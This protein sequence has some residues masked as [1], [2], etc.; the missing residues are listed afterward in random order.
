MKK[1]LLCLV[2]SMAMVFTTADSLV[3][4]AERPTELQTAVGE[5]QEETS[6][7]Q[8][9]VTKQPES[10]QE[11]VS[12]E[13]STESDQVEDTA[14]DTETEKETTDSDEETTDSEEAAD[15]DEEATDSGEATDSDEENMDSG[16]TTDSVEETTEPETEETADSKAQSSEDRSD[17]EKNDTDS[18]LQVEYHSI[19]EII[20]FLDQEKA[21]KADAVIYTERP[22]LTAPYQAGALSDTTLRSAAAM[23]RQIRFIAGLSYELQLNDE[24]NHISQAAALLNSANQELCQ[25]PSRPEGMS[26]ELFE[27]GRKGVSNSNLAY[28]G[29]QSQTLNGTIIETWMAD[30]D[31]YSQRGRLLQP[32]L[33]QIGFGVVQDGNGMYSAMYT[34]DRSDKGATVFGVAWPAQ[35]MPVDYFDREL[36]WSVSTGE[37]LEASD[38]RVTLTREA[39]GKEWTFSAEKSDGSFAVD[40]DDCG[41]SGCISFRP[42][43]SDISE[44]ADGDAFQVEITKDE[45]PY[46]KYRVRFFAY[47]KEEE[48]TTAPEDGITDEDTPERYTVNFESNGGTVVPAQSI[49]ENDK[50]IL[51]EQP[52]KEGSFFD[53]W[54][55]EEELENKWDFET[56]VV[57]ADIT[58]YAKWIGEEE[59]VVEPTEEATEADTAYSVTYDM[60]GI[61]E[62]IA[63][64]TINEGEILTQPDIPVAEDYIFEAW[65]QEQECINLWDFETD[66][67]TQDTVLYAKW[68]QENETAESADDLPNTAAEEVRID[69]SAE[70][71]DTRTNKI[72]PRVYNGKAYEPSVK[73]TAFNGKRR[74]T[75]KKNKDYKLQY[76]NNVHAGEDKATVTISGMGKYTGSVTKTFTITPKSVKKLKI[77]TG[78]KL[79]GDKGVAIVIYDGTVRLNNGWFLAEYI[80]AQDPKKAKI[81]IKPKETTTDYTGSVTSKL[82][83]YDV[84]KE[85]YINTARQEITGDTLYTGKA[86]KR[87]VKLTIED[88]ELRY[89][90]DYKVQYKNNVNA[91]TAVM[92]ITGKGQYKGKI[93]NTFNIGKV[94]LNKKE[95]AENIPQHVTIADISAKTFSGREQKPAVTI[96]TMG[97]K[98]LTLNKDYTVTYSNNVHAGTATITIAGI[99]SNCN[100]KTSIKFK[101]EPQQIKKAAVKLIRG[102]DGAPNTI[103]LTYNKKTL[104]EYADYII[105][106]YGEMKNKK[107]P[108]TIEG[109]SD[110]TGNVTKKLSV[111]APEDDP[112]SGSASSSKNINRQNYGSYEGCIVNSYLQ[113]NDDGT[114]MRVEHIGQQNVCIESYTAD[115]KFIDKKMI[116]AELPKFGGFYSGKDYYFLVFGQDNPNEDNTVEVIRIVKYDKSWERKGS[117]GIFGGNTVSPFKN[118]SLRMVEYENTL[119]IRTCH[120]MY[121]SSDGKQHQANVA[122]SMDIPNMEILEQYLWLSFS[123]YSSHS[124]NQFILRDGSD[125]LAV[126]HG[127][128]YPRSVALAKYNEKIGTPGILGKSSTRIAALAIGGNFGNPATGVSI[129]GFE[130]SDTAY[131]IAG[132][133]VDQTATPYNTGGVRNIY[134][135]STR[136]DNFSAAG[137]TVHWITDHQYIEYTDAKGEQKKTPA[138][139]VSTPHLVKI[140][141]NEMMVLWTEATIAIENNKPVTASSSQKCVL[142]NGAGEPVSGVYSFD[143]P[144]SDCK[145]IVDN[146]RL[147]WYYTNNSAPVFCTLN[148]NDVRNQPK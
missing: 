60:Q 79:P 98:K 97:N 103:A 37:T 47:T 18:K 61:G 81:T 30:Q 45:K 142:L 101:I 102:K 96:K 51:P 114:F 148:I 2:L 25:E 129:G 145:P 116:K 134:V 26:E 33:E 104:Q 21:D 48:E 64:E 55:Q 125:L 99:G 22:D 54:Y 41:Q 146:G 12:E 65:Y 69:L 76:A 78:S 68:V 57:E 135:T 43:T 113:K 36:P 40:N 107:I 17:S 42:D 140:S 50:I 143:G 46:L 44:Y 126:D 77:M 35:N 56:D 141:G 110:F 28:T 109:R 24:Y 20:E 100:G 117:V 128:A 106:E 9:G 52:V 71:T 87:D 39:D 85:N 19:S 136:K 49:A 63:S 122:I 1:R 75:L 121:R 32:S 5:T 138:A 112:D 83:V 34:E 108:V 29:E 80:D 124:F 6:A 105:T 111:E 15:S 90:K 88:T 59:E 92:I 58:L 31:E 72:A 3:L 66:V 53:D 16:E 10:G 139:S 137:N 119:Y 95:A 133:S 27:Q 131:L 82:T 62:Q 118:G 70:L 115:Q 8:E 73:V 11:P 144:I 4:A 132:N 67:I 123:T 127:D 14:A 89:N 74:V 147:I 23:V 91:G 94:D 84:P 120:Q 86:I 13:E 7:S 38:I 93:V 130:A